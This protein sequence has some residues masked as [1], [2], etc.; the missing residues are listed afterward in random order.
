MRRRR[1]LT[2]SLVAACTFALAT[3]TAQAQRVDPAVD[4]LQGN[5]V[6]FE[7]DAL[8]SDE[9]DDLDEAT[10]R[11]QDDGGYVKVV[12]LGQPVTDYDSARDYA[13][14]VRAALG[15]SGRVI[16]YTP[17]EVAVAS[18]VDPDDEIDDAEQAAADAING[19]RSLEDATVAA[20]DELGAG[21]GGSDGGSGGIPWAFLLL[22]VAVPVGLL[23]VLWFA[24]RKRRA[25]ATA[26]SAEE[27]G[28]AETTV[29]Q[30][31]D[32]VANDLLD[33]A[34]LVDQPDM[35]AAARE[36]FG[37]GAELFTATQEE[38]EQ[39]DT[40]EELEAVFPRV[41]QAGWHLDTARALL[42]GGEA[43]SPP[44]VPPLFPPHVVAAPATVP[45]T[46]AGPAA[47]RS[48]PPEPHYRQQGAS[49][50]ITAAAMAAMAMLSR[51]GMSTPSTRPSMDDG[52][53]GSWA[54][55]LPS[56]PA[57]GRGRGGGFGGLG[58]GSRGR[59]GGTVS[60]SSRGRGRGM[61]RR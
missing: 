36:A 19:G 57:A 31:V 18:N 61:G 22:V 30:T 24:G 28:A 27:I 35:P 15:G 58:G 45:A 38:L 3:T 1:V 41:V 14:D 25:R 60:P 33:L 2:G 40:R 51:R 20:A 16:V 52:G 23:V 48:A 9:L 47:Q 59:G 37:Q 42:E 39:A 56:L 12:V 10:R 44:E 17:D 53:F 49:P 8:S 13:D 4:D 32:K 43:P 46:E 34:D 54:N 29:R 50:W 26:M 55:G 6:T 11:L 7:E 21:S 5:D